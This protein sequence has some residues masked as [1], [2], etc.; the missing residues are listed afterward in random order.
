MGVWLYLFFDDVDGEKVFLTNWINYSDKKNTKIS[1]N[2]NFK[3]KIIIMH[4]N[5]YPKILIRSVSI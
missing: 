4:V 1:K 3:K 5:G 2:C